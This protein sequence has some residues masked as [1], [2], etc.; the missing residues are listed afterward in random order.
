[1]RFS[2]TILPLALFALTSARPT[3]E[4]VIDIVADI[5]TADNGPE[6]SYSVNPTL[7]QTGA[8]IATSDVPTGVLGPVSAS[9]SESSTAAAATADT[10][11]IPMN[12]LTAPD[13]GPTDVGS[14]STVVETATVHQSQEASTTSSGIATTSPTDNPEDAANVLGSP[15]SMLGMLLVPLLAQYF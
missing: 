11:S 7:V 8:S 5:L 14:M 9:A 4:P 2:R 13:T 1:M 15:V 12:I 10:T 3:E 6:S